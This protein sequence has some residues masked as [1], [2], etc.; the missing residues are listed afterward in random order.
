MDSDELPRRIPHS[1]RIE[2][3]AVEELEDG[4]IVH[5]TKV[6]DVGDPEYNTWVALAGDLSPK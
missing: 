2:V 4:T 1:S 3:P 6:I 5:G